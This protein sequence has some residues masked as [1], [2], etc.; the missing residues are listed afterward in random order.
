[1]SFHID[2]PVA[3]RAYLDGL[4][5]SPQAKERLD[6][7]VEEFIADIP[8]EFRLNPENRLSP[9]SPYFLVQHIILDIWG[10]HGVHAID[11]YVRDDKARF[12]A[13][14]IVFIEHH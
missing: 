9:D 4:P 12:G 10:D 5:L 8:D 2:I 1:L 14:L 13:L 6:R 7:F 11:F 3:E